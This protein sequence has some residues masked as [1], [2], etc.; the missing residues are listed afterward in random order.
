MQCVVGFICLLSC[1]SG[2]PMLCCGGELVIISTKSSHSVILAVLP[3]PILVIH[4]LKDSVVDPRDAPLLYNAASEPKELWLLPNAEHCGSYFENR[5]EYVQ[6]VCTFFDLHLRRHRVPPLDAMQGSCLVPTLC[7][8]PTLCLTS[9]C[10]KQVNIRKGNP[11]SR[12]AHLLQHVYWERH[13]VRTFSACAGS[14]ILGLK[15]VNIS[16]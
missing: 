3:R 11:T 8:A 4:G 12:L 5:V 15:W 7:E 10:P 9:S 14:L 2:L 16:A 13:G 6:K 1:L